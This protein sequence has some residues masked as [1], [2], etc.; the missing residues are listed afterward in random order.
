MSWDQLRRFS[1]QLSEVEADA[2]D[3][4]IAIGG[5]RHERYR[6]VVRLHARGRRLQQERIRLLC[7][8]QMENRGAKEVNDARPIGAVA[9][10]D[11]RIEGLEA[12][13][14]STQP[15]AGN[16]LVLPEAD[17]DERGCREIRL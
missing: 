11:E 6:G 3:V 5:R 17:A 12:P 10:E 2:D 8:S 15:S 13:D 16:H 9:E 7:A 1:E 4:D 14:D